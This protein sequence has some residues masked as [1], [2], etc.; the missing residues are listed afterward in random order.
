MRSRVAE[1]VREEQRR[2]ML[3]LT[4]EE[5]IEQALALGRRDVEFYMAAN[6][7]DRPTAMR[8]LREVTRAGRNPS[9]SNDEL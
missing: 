4:V 6:Q 8:R 2:E 5:R 7:V 1:Q 3:A 9:K